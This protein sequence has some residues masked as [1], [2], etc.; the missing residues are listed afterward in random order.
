MAPP[1][2]TPPPGPVCPNL[3]P[4]TQAIT[5]AATV[6]KLA[7][8]PILNQNNAA[9]S[10]E[11]ALIVKSPP[12]SGYGNAVPM[13]KVPPAHIH[14]SA[15]SAPPFR[16]PPGHIGGPPPGQGVDMAKVQPKTPPGRVSL[17]S[18]VPPAGPVAVTVPEE[19][20]TNKTIMAGAADRI[21]VNLA[22]EASHIV[23]A[24]PTHIPALVASAPASAEFAPAA[25]PGDSLSSAGKSL[26]PGGTDG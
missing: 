15:K 6:A 21:Q 23:K 19:A 18:K 17:R 24:P 3:D 11:S 8:Q 12:Y 22:G 5:V 2:A 25:G 7:S 4:H 26:P 10:A 14:P 20:V 1:G 9:A 16:I 13:V